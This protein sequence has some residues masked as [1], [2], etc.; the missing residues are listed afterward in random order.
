MSTG[1]AR[2]SSLH[3]RVRARRTAVQACYQWLI[4]NQPVSAV[5]KEFESDRAELKKAD[6]EYFSDLMKGV[7][8]C[9]GEIDSAITP[10]LDRPLAELNT[11]EH[12][13]LMLAVYE[14]IHHPELP[15]RV[16]VN[17]AVDL[18][19]MFG[20]EQSYRYINGV[21]DKAAHRIR[22]SEIPAN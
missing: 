10:L 7:A 5:I 12:A 11:V 15:W 4:N 21:L 1:R 3:A 8:R 17:E 22:A 19:K 9:A 20:A 18:A 16:I 2:Q 14:L 13:I 6:K